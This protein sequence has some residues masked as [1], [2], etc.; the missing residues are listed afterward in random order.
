MLIIDIKTGNPTKTHQY[1]L[2][3]YKNLV[4]NG[5]SNINFDEENHIYTSNSGQILP[6]VTHVLQLIQKWDYKNDFYADRG[7]YIHKC[8][9]AAMQGKLDFDAIE[10][11]ILQYV[12]NWLKFLDEKGLNYKPY[13]NNCKIEQKYWHE[14]YNYAGTID[15]QY[16]LK[17]EKTELWLVYLQ[18]D[19]H[20]VEKVKY[21]DQLFNDFLC[22][23]RTYKLREGT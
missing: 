23:L 15:I 20:K 21:T 8:C 10:P 12:E 6:S 22:I 13:N 1:Q 11:E 17:S 2:C 3:A 5:D 16:P 18:P 4:E 9:Y 7:T 19:S 14:K